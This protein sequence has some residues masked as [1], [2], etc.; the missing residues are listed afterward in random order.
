[1]KC[2]VCGSE[3]V[4][5][6]LDLGEVPLANRLVTEE[7]LDIPVERYPLGLE[8]CK[9]CSFVQL[10]HIVPP[11]IL[12]DGYPYATGASSTA[13]EHFRHMAMEITK[14]LGLRQGSVV[15]DI[16]SND[17]TLLKGFLDLGMNIMGVEP[18]ENIAQI[19]LDA[20][21][22]TIVDF[23]NSDVVS[24]I[25]LKHGKADVITAANVFT[26]LE[27]P[28]SLIRDVKDLLK[29]DGVFVIEIYYIWSLIRN[30]AFD[31][32]YHEHM[33]YFNIRSLSRLLESEGME[34]FHVV[35]VNTQGGSLRIYA[36][37]PGSYKINKSVLE[38]KN[39][40]PSFAS[41]FELYREFAD[42]VKFIRESIVRFVKEE[43]A[44]NKR[45]AGYGAAAK[46]TTL[47]NYCEIGRDEI[48]YV[49]DRNI[50]KQGKYIPGTGIPIVSPEYLIND[51]PDVV[52]IFAWNIADEVKGILEPIRRK[53]TRIF[54][55]LPM[56]EEMV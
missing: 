46:A 18:S 33:S 17:G 42:R 24:E 1:M 26:H 40:E 15:V 41:S 50:L 21:I 49:A 52:I 36:S 53:G 54:V 28:A 27:D 8:Y 32:V 23:F 5:E 16:G 4:E 20:G 56:L 22:P 9:E 11:K 51:K 43:K 7:N 30:G 35:P 25:S 6:F 48:E 19:A 34:I 3:D 14:T 29:D 55:P 44:K 45:I 47:L 13:T 31:Q 10:T 39:Q 37:F 12:Y 2:M 38:M